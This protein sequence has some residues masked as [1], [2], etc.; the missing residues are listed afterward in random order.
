MTTQPH[1]DTPPIPHTSESKT[2]IQAKALSDRIW[3]QLKED[4]S[5]YR[6]LTGDRPTGPL[7]IGHY[8][9]SL[10]NRI[11]LQE[12]GIESFIVIA[13][14]QVLTDRDDVGQIQRHVRDLILDYASVG[15]NPFEH[16]NTTIFC[17][18]QIP[19]LN[20]LIFPFSTL[21]LT[22]FRIIF[23]STLTCKSL[24]S[25]M[26]HHLYNCLWLLLQPLMKEERISF[27]PFQYLF[28][29]FL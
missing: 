28:L 18:S 4:A 5:K 3:D 23:P 6:M 25:N 10:A 26:I 7:H 20:Q 9:G 19:E 14:Y 24:I 21:R 12:M 29:T 1:H 2:F 17:H 22:P 8:F 27:F 13:D 15:L 11:K 16:D